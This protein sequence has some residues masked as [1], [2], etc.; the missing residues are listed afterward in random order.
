MMNLSRERSLRIFSQN[1]LTTLGHVSLLIN[2]KKHEYVGPFTFPDIDVGREKCERFNEKELK[3]S[4]DLSKVWNLK[5]C[6]LGGINFRS[7]M[8]VHSRKVR[9][10]L[11]RLFSFAWIY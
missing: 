1:P 11:F 8:N 5:G 3:C 10:L 9:F 6:G 4:S 7:E 2:A